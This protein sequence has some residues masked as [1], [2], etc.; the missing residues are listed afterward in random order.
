MMPCTL[1]CMPDALQEKVADAG[2]TKFPAR[3]E[4]GKLPQGIRCDGR[5]KAFYVYRTEL[6]VSEQFHAK[7][8]ITWQAAHMDSS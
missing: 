5:S 2:E 6:V 7:R 3:T 8:R 4:V 1:V